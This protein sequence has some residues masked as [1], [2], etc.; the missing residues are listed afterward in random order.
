MD[1]LIKNI[2][3]RLYKALKAKTSLK[4]VSVGEAINDAIRLWLESE[5]RHVNDKRFW[6][7]VYEGKY[8]LFCDGQFVGAFESEDRMLEET[9]K[10]TKCYAM[11]KN[12]MSGE[13]EL[14]GAF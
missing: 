5:S 8:A 4:G 6:D 1:V 3:E 7:A 13:G 10:Y 12:W 11:H 14:V 2:D 9:K